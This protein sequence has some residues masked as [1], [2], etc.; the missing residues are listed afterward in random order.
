MKIDS[1]DVSL[2]SSR[3][4][5]ETHSTRTETGFL[6]Y[7]LVDRHAANRRA[8]TPARGGEDN[9]WMQPTVF[10]GQPAVSLTDQF[11]QELEKMR[12]ILESL[13]A[14]LNRMTSDNSTCT[15][16]SLYQI[17]MDS[18]V[19]DATSLYRYEYSETQS[20]AYERTEE[21]GFSANG[22][23]QTADGKEID[24]NFEMDMAHYFFQESTY[25]RTES[26]YQFLDPL[27]IRTDAAAP[28]LAGAGF[29]F[30]LNL[31]GVEEDIRPPVPGTGFLSLDLNGDGEIN[32]GSELFGPAT[33]DGFGELAA[34]DE[35]GN[36]W[37]DENDT[38][39]DS[40]T[41]WGLN[42]DG[43]MALTRIQDAGIGAIYLDAVETQFDIR[44]NENELM[45]RV[46]NSSFAVHEDGSISAVQ[47][48][49]WVV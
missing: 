41:I 20:F 35:D 46:R 37:I 33:G 27:V 10:R 47:E 39:F 45:A 1:F 26:G 13:M 43:A 21:T 36:A 5:S 34:Y 38:I 49:D 24:F 23:I 22:I 40:L 4:V 18:F 31:D 16:T 8:E 2:S 48:M 15:C 14:Q 12:Q 28:E 3:Y 44:D 11:R 32:D 17:Y 9:P 6:F 25:T 29:S 30:D 7:E 19:N 42:D